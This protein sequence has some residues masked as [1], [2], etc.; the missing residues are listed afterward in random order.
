MSLLANI[1]VNKTSVGSAERLVGNRTLN[2]NYQLCP[3][4]NG[5]DLAGRPVCLDSFY[6][7]Y[8]G[9]NSPLDRIKVENFLRPAYMNYVTQSA[10]GISG[11]DADYGSNLDATA[12]ASAST[13][14]LNHKNNT[15]QFGLISSEAINAN[16][17]RQDTLAANAY[18]SDQDKRALLA[19]QHRNAQALGIGYAS[20]NRMNRM[21]AVKV[22][23][24]TTYTYNRNSDYMY[25]NNHANQTAAYLALNDYKTPMHPRSTSL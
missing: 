14:H 25:A 23:P 15:G 10:S 1:N 13:Q 5:Q 9:C 12:T 7:R 24:N 18:Q 4:W 22:N 6:T 16:S 19:Q 2:P 21:N 3:V 17:G 11:V 8:A 20:Q